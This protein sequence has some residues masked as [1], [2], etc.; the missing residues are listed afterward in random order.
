M[1]LIFRGL[2]AECPLDAFTELQFSSGSS[3]LKV[4]KTFPSKVLHIREKGLQLFDALI[5]VV[6]R[7]SF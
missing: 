2:L 3:P 4:G 6:D 7:R 5:Q 1:G